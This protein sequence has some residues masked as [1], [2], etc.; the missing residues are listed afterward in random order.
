ML[1]L[2]WDMS[3]CA[4]RAPPEYMKI[5]LGTLTVLRVVFCGLLDVVNA[6]RLPASGSA[7]VYSVP[8][9]LDPV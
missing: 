8:P 3:L 2:L 4:R 6:L 7:G 1:W 5:G 9:Q